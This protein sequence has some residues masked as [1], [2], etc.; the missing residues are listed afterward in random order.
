MKNKLLNGLILASCLVFG[1]SFSNAQNT[2]TNEPVALL[3]KSSNNCAVKALGGSLSVNPLGAAVYQLGIEVPNGG[4]LTP[5]VALTYNSQSGHGI[6]GYG[7]NISGISVITRGGKNKFKDGELKAVAYSKDD[8]FFLDG[9]KLILD[10]G[11]RGTDGSVYSPEGNPFTKVIMHGNADTPTMWFE[12]KTTDGITYRYGDSENSRESWINKKSITHVASWYVTYVQD[13]YGNIRTYGY[14][15]DNLVVYPASIVYGINAKN[16]RN[17]VNYVNFR[18]ETIGATTV[19]FAKEDNTGIIAK[20]LSAI[21]VTTVSN[22]VYRHYDLTYNDTSDGTTSKYSRLVR[23]NVRNGKNESLNPINLDWNYLSALNLTSNRLSVETDENLSY[24]KEEKDACNFAAIDLNNDGLADIIRYIPVK[25]NNVDEIHLT[26]SFNKGNGNFE[27]VKTYNLGKKNNDATFAGIHPLD[28]N[29]DGYNDFVIPYYVKNGD[30][31]N[32]R[33]DVFWGNITNSSVYLQSKTYIKEFKDIPIL[34]SYDYD[35]NGIEDLLFVEKNKQGTVY[36]ST[37]LS[38]DTNMKPSNGI[39]AIIK[40]NSSFEFSKAPERIF[41]SDYNGD[42]ITDLMILYNG[43]YEMHINCCRSCSSIKVYGNNLKNR[44][45]ITQGDFNGDGRMDFVYDDGAALSIALNNGDGTFTI[46]E[47]VATGTYQDKNTDKDNDK[48]ALIAYDI[49]HDGKTDL[50]VSKAQLEYHGGFNDYYSYKNVDV[51][52]FCSTGEGLRKIKSIVRSS[53]TD[54]LEGKIFIGD[55]DGDG[56]PELAN[57]GGSLTSVSNGGSTNVYVYKKNLSSDYIS[58]GRVKSIT[59]EFMRTNYI[60]YASGTSSAIYS[61]TSDGAYPVNCYTIALPLV[62]RISKDCGMAGRHNI[63][64]KYGG[65]KVQMTGGGL[66]GFTTITSEDKTSGVK[67]ETKILKRDSK[68]LIPIETLTTQ[69][70]GNDSSTELTYT[71]I[72]ETSNRNYFSYLSKTESTDF[73]G[74]KTITESEYDIVKGVPVEQRVVYAN[75]MY[76]KNI[77]SDYINKNGMWLPTLLEKIQKHSDD[78]SEYSQKTALVYDEKGDIASKTEFSNTPLALTTEYTYDCFGNILTEETYGKG[79]TNNKIVNEYDK[80][81]RYLVRTADSVTGSYTMYTYDYWGNVLTER[82]EADIENGTVTSYTYDNWGI[83]TNV[84]FPEGTTTKYVRDWGRSDR[85][86]Y[87]IEEIPQNGVWTRTWYDKCGNEVQVE[88][89]G[90]N[91]ISIIK[92]TNYN[93][94][95]QIV[96]VSNIEGSKSGYQNFS[97]D[98]RGRLTYTLKSSGQSVIYTYGN[99]SVTTTTVNGSFTKV[100]DAWGNVKQSTDPQAEVNY[101]YKSNGKPCKTESNGV[102][103]NMEYDCAGNRISLSDPDAGLLEYTYSADGKLLT[104]TDGRGILT[105]YSYDA[106][107]RILSKKTGDITVSNTYGTSG[108]GKS[109]IVM[110]TNGNMSE[111]Y[112]YDKYGRVVKVSRNTGGKGILEFCYEFDEF[113]QL[114]KK[115]MPGGLVVSYTYDKYGFKTQAKAGENVI[116]Q[117]GSCNGLTAT[118]SFCNKLTFRVDTDNNGFEKYRM[119]ANGSDILEYLSS[120]YNVKTG[121]LSSRNRTGYPEETFAYDDLDRLVSVQ[122]DDLNVMQMEYSAGGNIEYKTG[123]GGYYYNSAGKPHAVI[124]V[125]NEDGAYNNGTLLTHFNDINR[126][127]YIGLDATAERLNFSYGPDEERWFSEYVVKGISKR[128]VLYAGEYEKITENGT[129]REFYYLDGNTIVIKQNGSFKPYYAFTDNLGS[130]LSVVDENGTKVFEASYDA[131]GNQSVTLNN[132]GLHRGYTGHEMLSE[133]GI[134]NMNGRLYDPVL[135]RFLSPD[136]Y[137]QSPYNSQNYNRYTYC[138]NNPLKYNDPTGQKWWHWALA[139]FLLDPVTT[140]VTASSAVSI[141]PIA[142]PTAYSIGM[143]PY[144][145]TVISAL[146][147]SLSYTKNI[148]NAFEIDNS[149]FSGNFKQI[150]SKWT[151]QSVQAGFGNSIAHI[152]NLS[153]NVDKVTE[154]D[155]MVA[156]SGV[157]HGNAAFTIGHYSFGPNG[158]E[159]TWKDNLFVH[160]Y[161][162][163]IQSQL[164]GIFYLP[165]IAIP[166][167]ISAS[168]I[169][170]TPHSYHWYEVHASKCGAMYFDQYYGR[171]RKGFAKGKTNYFDIEYFI[172][173]KSSPYHNPRTGEEQDKLFPISGTKFNIF[174]LIALFI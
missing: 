20:R 59:D 77:Y 50:F 150:L 158:Y 76:K 132:I 68:R 26:V 153:G 52:W 172:N 128:S 21:D 28:F 103:F 70:L 51:E 17:M 143:T 135:G 79:I 44:H 67:S 100:T 111:S 78:T 46:K 171:G 45:R 167:L 1:I 146:T 87:Y 147:P 148:K 129:T 56:F 69:I 33:L 66:L 18:Y 108:Y 152:L 105:S 49:D 96:N 27:K 34:L 110:T 145:G 55:F 131:W 13:K 88:S 169:T 154:K 139:A 124:S 99:R 89:V 25:R 83:K 118:S 151:K 127:D 102:V 10:S 93:T 74:N 14:I 41:V 116:Y 8:N 119:L 47:K 22:G 53:E 126:I 6:A 160:E 62:S 5:Q 64:Y 98:S 31:Y 121:N 97:Y 101:T 90:P 107:G 173:D 109:R 82:N 3:P 4:S 23:I 9:C 84:V 85:N 114:A 162:H 164:F 120:T 122:K 86:Y 37:V 61:S 24:I 92:N 65:L 71:T 42:G 174:D 113:G 91:S 63:D 168:G 115:T 170:G 19:H 130:I 137:V 123:I 142:I 32:I 95:G 166:S 15:K 134:I 138:L 141:V 43:G 94:K 163:Y 48:Y 40:Y 155:G 157:T 136:N 125:D 29:G 112:E 35:N 117:F 30:S 7:F 75:D 144:G 81:G 57:Y 161:G 106:A 16:S 165:I 80:T 104:E 11:T 12:V 39:D 133:F 156:L 58:E 72:A 159:A 140:T 60:Y 54:A 73:D 149:M 36:K 2:S 38:F